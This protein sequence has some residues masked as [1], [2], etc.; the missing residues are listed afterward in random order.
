MKGP[1]FCA[2]AALLI[3]LPPALSRAA[4]ATED[5][6]WYSTAQADSGADLY[7]HRCA[8]C[9]GVRLE[10][11][12]G[13]SLAGPKFYGKFGGKKMSKLWRSVGKMPPSAPGSVPKPEVVNIIAYILRQNG[14]P[15]GNPLTVEPSD[16]ERVIP[17]KL[18]AKS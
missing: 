2:G 15:G 1:V 16:L 12:K 11:G 9:H 3:L 14:L 8:A 17:S 10:G 7:Y 18:P 5:P 4:S 13:I 6:G